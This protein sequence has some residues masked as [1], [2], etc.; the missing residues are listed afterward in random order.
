MPI[1]KVLFLAGLC[2]LLGACA[3]RGPNELPTPDLPGLSCQDTECPPA[4]P[5]TRPGAQVPIYRT[6]DEP[7]WEERRT[8]VWGEKTVPVYQT[9]KIPVTIKVWDPCT[10]CEKDVR[11]WDKEQRVQVGV[12]RVHACIGYKTER[13]QTGSCPKK[14]IIGWRSVDEA[15]CK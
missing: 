12:R 8:P 9:R 4:E 10:K 2:A 14:E 1:P 15:P 13:V 3:T 11:L 5:V 6:R 7:I